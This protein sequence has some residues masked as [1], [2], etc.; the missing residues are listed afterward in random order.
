MTEVSAPERA[1]AAVVQELLAR[2]RESAVV[3]GLAV[4]VRAEVRFTHDV[5]VAVIV[6]DDAEAEQLV[7]DLGSAATHRP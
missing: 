4:S 1:L 6:A 3:G 2:G 5:D 7:H